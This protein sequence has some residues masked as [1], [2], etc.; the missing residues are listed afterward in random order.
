V[1]KRYD[2]SVIFYYSNTKSLYQIN[3]ARKLRR[4]A[5][6]KSIGKLIPLKE[7]LEIIAQAMLE[8]HELE[9]IEYLL[10]STLIEDKTKKQLI[11]Y[12]KKLTRKSK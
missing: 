12:Q 10:R 7:E 3:A 9:A 6:S 1:I 8:E 4:F 2:E 5:L 11:K